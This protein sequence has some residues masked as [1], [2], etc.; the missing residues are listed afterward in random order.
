MAI[1]IFLPVV[2]HMCVFLF[3][4]SIILQS[5]HS[6]QLWLCTFPCLVK[7]SLVRTRAMA[8][9]RARLQTL[10]ITAN[11]GGWNEAKWKYF[12][13]D[14]CVCLCLCAYEYRWIQWMG[15]FYSF[16]LQSSLLFLGLWTWHMRLLSTDLASL[17]S[18]CEKELIQKCI[19]SI[20][21]LLFVL[22]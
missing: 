15:L 12:F 18:H 22:L 11:D 8:C 9:V 2:Y 13:V 14:M 10:S 3:F 4:V 17:F 6:T 21:V 5:K 19:I 16:K 1:R 7:S 20:L